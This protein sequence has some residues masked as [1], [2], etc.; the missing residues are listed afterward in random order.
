MPSD[1]ASTPSIG[2]RKVV[3][4]WGMSGT[5]MAGNGKSCGDAF[6]PGALRVRNVAVMV[7]VTPSR[8]ISSFT[9][10]AGGGFVHH[11]TELLHA[12]HALAIVFEHNIL[13]FEPGFFSGAA[14][15]HARDLDAVGFFELQFARTVARDLAQVHTQ[16]R[17]AGAC[18]RAEFEDL[19]S[20]G[21]GGAS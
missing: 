11:P 16:I 10:A 2:L 19:R 5:W 12:F 18:R 13:G 7:W 8:L 3:K 15:L 21:I 20:A 1:S 6:Q 17:P 4:I 9:L 14:I